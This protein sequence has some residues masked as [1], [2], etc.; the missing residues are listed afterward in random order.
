MDRKRRAHNNNPENVFNKRLKLGDFNN[1]ATRKK[2]IRTANDET[3]LRTINQAIELQA[4]RV[5]RANEEKDLNNYLHWTVKLYANLVAH[6]GYE[7][8]SEV[9]L[10]T[11]ERL[12]DI[13][14]NEQTGDKETI[15]TTFYVLL[16]IATVLFFEH[17]QSVQQ[18][19]D[20]I[21]DLSKILFNMLEENAI[22]AI[23]YLISSEDFNKLTQSS[24]YSIY[25]FPDYNLNNIVN[26]V[27][28][29]DNTTGKQ[30]QTAIIPYGMLKKLK[31]LIGPTL[32]E[33]EIL[34]DFVWKQKVY[35]ISN[36]GVLNYLKELKIPESPVVVNEGGKPKTRKRKN[37][38]TK[39]SKSKKMR[40]KKMRTKKM[41]TKKTRSKRAKNQKA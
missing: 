33:N 11:K 21:P 9:V 29:K 14:T 31:E 17:K 19:R 18:Y 26:S 32:P 20:Y 27:L 22:T 1:V 3:N 13:A 15:P 10:G 5:K 8:V 24:K 28:I 39:K 35:S 23:I 36:T 30:Y 34:E 16:L 40:T 25:K 41:R 12:M 38:K 37:K 2:K 7:L 6:F 4:K